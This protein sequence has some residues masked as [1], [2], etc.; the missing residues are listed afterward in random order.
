M[1]NKNAILISSV[2]G[3]AAIV[4]GLL[5]T[6]AQTVSIGGNAIKRVLLISVDGLHASDLSMLVKLKP[7]SSL[8]ALSK[9]QTLPSSERSG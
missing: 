4:S 3:I 1:K 2:L 6:R 5:V 8:A 9:T 7:D